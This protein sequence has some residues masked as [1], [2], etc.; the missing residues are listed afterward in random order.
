MLNVFVIGA[1]ETRRNINE[2]LNNVLI[3]QS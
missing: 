1:D 2:K 3:W